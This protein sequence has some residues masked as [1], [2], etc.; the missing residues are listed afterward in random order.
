M[1]LEDRLSKQTTPEE[2]MFFGVIRTCREHI[3]NLANDLE[4]A[5]EQRRYYKQCYE[6]LSGEHHKLIQILEQ[7]DSPT[8]EQL[9]LE[10]EESRER[11]RTAA[12]ELPDV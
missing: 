3:V 4:R 6:A 12:K 7:Y 9:H 11:L 5:I 1:A 10:L 8:Q 2:I